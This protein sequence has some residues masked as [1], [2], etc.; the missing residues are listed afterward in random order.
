[1]EWIAQTSGYLVAIITGTTGEKWYITIWHNQNNRGIRVGTIYAV[2]CYND[3][4][5]IPNAEIDRA[6]QKSLKP[7]HKAAQAKASWNAGGQPPALA[8]KH[9]TEPPSRTRGANKNRSSSKS[10]RNDWKCF[11]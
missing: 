5:P 8:A 10:R 2:P 4:T 1:M 9:A 6:M 11:K 3:G 7:E